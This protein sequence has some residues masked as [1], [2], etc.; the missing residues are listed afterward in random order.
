MTDKEWLK[1]INEYPEEDD[2]EVEEPQPKKKRKSHKEKG[3]K[4]R[5]PSQEHEESSTS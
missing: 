3:D 4:I 5:A 2:E 1:S